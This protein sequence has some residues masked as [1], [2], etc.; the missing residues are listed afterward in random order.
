MN[1]TAEQVAF[2]TQSSI[3][4]AQT[5]TPALNAAMEHFNITSQRN[6]A[7][8][9]ATVAIE[10]AHLT[11]TEESLYYKS[12]ERLASLYPRAFRNAEAAEPYV[13]NP[14]GLSALLYGG[15]HGRGLIQ[16]TWRANYAE[17]GDALGVDYVGVPS[18]VC[19]P[20]HAALTASWYWA[21]SGCITAADDG[22]MEEVTRLVN[23]PRKMHLAERTALYNANVAA[24]GL[25]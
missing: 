10:S 7:A 12:A 20:D 9:L 2:Y 24:M 22:D 16:L 18:L 19:K 21:R 23:G 13:R 8:F 4:N 5:Y 3:F 15:F 17:A 1:L 25:A 6:I 14:S 11:T